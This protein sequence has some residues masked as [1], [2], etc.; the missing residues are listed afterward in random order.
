MKNPPY[1]RQQSLK[2]ANLL[3][4]TSQYTIRKCFRDVFL[5]PN[6]HK[7]YIDSNSRHINLNSRQL[8]VIPDTSISIPDTLIVI[9]DTSIAIPDN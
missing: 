6:H 1:P 4:K 8:K 7:L 2:N 3:L 9:P 5:H